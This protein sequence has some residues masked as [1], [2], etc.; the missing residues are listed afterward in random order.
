MFV[1]S[2][3]KWKGSPQWV[4]KREEAPTCEE[5]VPREQSNAVPWHGRS[6]Q[7]LLHASLPV[8][9]I[10]RGVLCSSCCCLDISETFGSLCPVPS[11]VRTGF[12]TGRLWSY[13]LCTLVSVGVPRATTL[14]Y[15][16]NH[17]P[18][19]RKH[20]CLVCWTST[21][22]FVFLSLIRSPWLWPVVFSRCLKYFS[23][24]CLFFGVVRFTS[25][26]GS[27]ETTQKRSDPFQR[28]A[29]VSPTC[30]LPLLFPFLNLFSNRVQKFSQNC[31]YLVIKSGMYCYRYGG[32]VLKC[33][34][35]N[36]CRQVSIRP[37]S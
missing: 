29:C 34:Y 12:G 6:P 26:S 11:P 24:Y 23:H 17:G 9:G 14:L 30:Y 27:R 33:D 20:G 19:F 1:F 31:G 8:S 37:R 13:I 15:T 2:S 22:A 25:F 36:C 18:W 7:Q 28:H 3:M 16:P 35:H 4:G 10:P 21:T 32:V 5:L